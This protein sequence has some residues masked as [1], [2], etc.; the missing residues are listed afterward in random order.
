MWFFSN[1]FVIMLVDLMP[2]MLLLSYL[3]SKSKAKPIKSI[4]NHL[5]G[6]DQF[7]EFCACMCVCGPCGAHELDKTCVRNNALTS[8]HASG[9]AG[10]RGIRHGHEA[11]VMVIGPCKLSLVVCTLVNA[12]SPCV[13][14]CVKCVR[15][16][17]HAQCALSS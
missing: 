1:S 13:T 3:G 11:P 16:W 15:K 8:H 7:T 4:K 5:G 6:N 9:D 17:V 14:T 12:L 10:E 2:F